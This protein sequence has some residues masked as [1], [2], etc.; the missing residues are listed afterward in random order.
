MTLGVLGGTFNP[1]H[2]A[3]LRLAEEM[4]E[5]LGLERVLFVPAAQ[6]PLKASGVAPA[7]DR[8]EMTRL[9]VAGNPAFETAELEIERTGPSYTTD[10]LRELRLRQPGERL[11]FILGSDAMADL[12]QWHDA[13]ALF[14]LASFAVAE[15]PGSEG[16]SA[17]EL[18]P[19]ALAR[20]FED[21]AGGLLHPSGNE[22]RVVPSTPMAVSASDIRRRV[23]RGSSIRYLVP[24]AVACYIE[25]HDLYR[26]PD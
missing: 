9:A 19:T 23:A 1:I 21:G 16:R 11:W 13:A 6:P 8:L 12:G 26:T 22:L 2:C 18:L 7:V 3:H 20:S 10:T 15:R 25:K 14:E 5:A 24:D 4:R 17:R